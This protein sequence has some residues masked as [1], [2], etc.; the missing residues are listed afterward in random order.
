MYWKFAVK[1]ALL[2]SSVNMSKNIW[3]RVLSH[4]YRLILNN[5]NISMMKHTKI[6]RQEINMHLKQTKTCVDWSTHHTLD[7][8]RLRRSPNFADTGGGG[9]QSGCLHPEQLMPTSLLPWNSGG[10]LSSALRKEHIYNLKHR[11]DVVNTMEAHNLLGDGCVC[12]C[13]RFTLWTCAVA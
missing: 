12:V 3:K 8:K 4:T 11:S 7:S 5:E 1:V 6:W 9:G 10:L 2:S 13:A